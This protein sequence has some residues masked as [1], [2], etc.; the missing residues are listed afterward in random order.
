MALPPSPRHPSPRAAS[1]AA[2]PSSQQQQ[3]QPPPHSSLQPL[4]RGDVV[5]RS[6]S[7]AL[8]AAPHAA[9]HA[10]TAV[11]PL[12]AAPDAWGADDDPLRNSRA[13]IAAA[14]AAAAAAGPPSPRSPRPPSKAHRAAWEPYPASATALS[15]SAGPPL[16]PFCPQ[17]GLAPPGSPAREAAALQAEAE[18]LRARLAAAEEAAEVGGW[19]GGADAVEEGPSM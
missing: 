16:Q 5:W 12:P 8:P 13:V 3:Q 6:S 18:R 10:S 9:P 2:S 7:P 11:S 17:C 14:A 4:L 15:Y 19:G 1:P